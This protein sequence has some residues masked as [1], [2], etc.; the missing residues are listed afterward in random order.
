MLGGNECKA[1]MLSSQ[2]S[3]HMHPTEAPIC[4]DLGPPPP[5][6]HAAWGTFLP[7]QESASKAQRPF[8]HK[9]QLGVGQQVSWRWEEIWGGWLGRGQK[10]EQGEPRA[11]EWT[12]VRAAPGPPGCS[13]HTRPQGTSAAFLVWV[14]KLSGDWR[15][16]GRG[17]HPPPLLRQA[18]SSWLSGWLTVSP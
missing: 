2:K 18:V 10:A 16:P 8:N 4:S 7:L 9:Q 12:H 11:G 14:Q 1:D 5:G 13:S 15:S 3:T 17:A 6:E